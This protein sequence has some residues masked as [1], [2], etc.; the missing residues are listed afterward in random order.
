MNLPN[1]TGAARLPRRSPASLHT[2]FPTAHF[3]FQLPFVPPS[4]LARETWRVHRKHQRAHR[5]NRAFDR[6]VCFAPPATLPPRRGITRTRHHVRLRVQSR[7]PCAN[8]ASRAPPRLLL[9]EVVDELG[10][11]LVASEELLRFREQR[12]RITPSAVR[13]GSG[14][15]TL[16]GERAGAA[17]QRGP[18]PPLVLMRVE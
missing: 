14:P 7:Q 18:V 6:C 15:W 4:A 16:L 13:S 9:V 10:H 3:G 11:L 2:P 5:P 12:R 17:A 8:L 1:L